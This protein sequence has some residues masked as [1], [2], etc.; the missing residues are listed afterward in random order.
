MAWGTSALCSRCLHSATAEYSK[1]YIQNGFEHYLVN[2]YLFVVVTIGKLFLNPT[3]NMSSMVVAFG[4]TNTLYPYWLNKAREILPD[5]SYPTLITHADP[6]LLTVIS[7]LAFGSDN[8]LAMLYPIYC[9]TV[10]KLLMIHYDNP[11]MRIAVDEESLQEELQ[12]PILHDRLTTN[13]HLGFACLSLSCIVVKDVLLGYMA[14]SNIAISDIIFSHQLS[15]LVL[16]LVYKRQNDVAPMLVYNEG[17]GDVKTYTVST[18]L[19][20][21]NGLINYLYIASLYSCYSN[22]PNMGY[23]KMFVNFYIPTLWCYK[24]GASQRECNEYY[25]GGYYCYFLAL[26]G[27]IYF[28]R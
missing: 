6:I 2:I 18:V 13:K 24:I 27:V 19:L 3:F 1:K 23:A 10:G 11:Y 8:R 20:L 16:S 5:S 22:I 15:A 4:V 28:G 26:C 14:I 21:N 12:Q 7:P 9:M 25:I 17:I